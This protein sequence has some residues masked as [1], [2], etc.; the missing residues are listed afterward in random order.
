MLARLAWGLVVA[1][2]GA[3]AAAPVAPAG[4]QTPPVVLDAIVATVNGD[5]ITASDVRAVVHLA[6]PPGRAVA[7]PVTYLIDR[8]LMLDE[9]ERASQGLPPPEQVEARQREVEAALGAPALAQLASRDA[10]TAGRLAA[11]IR[12][13]LRIDAYLSQRFTAAA[14]PTDEE[15]AS[16]FATNAA[17]FVQPGTPADDAATARARAAL[18]ASRRQ[19]LIDAWLDGLR[20]RA[21]IVAAPR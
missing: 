13:D 8:A 15:V 5:A 19:A 11:W 6:W 21:D 17:R 9:V 18:V 2:A 4:A 20:R 14:Q 3:L 12:D 7:D 1:A 16:F 10:M